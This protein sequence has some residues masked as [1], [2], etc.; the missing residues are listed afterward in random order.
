MVPIG[1]ISYS[2]SAGMSGHVAIGSDGKITIAR[3]GKDRLWSDRDC[4]RGTSPE[5][6]AGQMIALAML[7]RVRFSEK[8]TIMIDGF[9]RVVGMLHRFHVR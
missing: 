3:R 8:V 2:S 1:A 6:A 4:C 9:V 5:K 7:R